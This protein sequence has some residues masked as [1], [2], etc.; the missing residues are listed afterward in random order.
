MG[1]F[2]PLLPVGGQPAV[3]RCVNIAEKAGIDD[4]LLVTGFRNTEVED[5]V[6][7]K[8]SK[9]RLTHNSSYM[10]G[11]FTSVC[12]GVSALKKENELFFLLP[13]DCCAIEPGI[14]ALLIESYDKNDGKCVIIPTH[15]GKR[16]HPP[17]IP[18][19]YIKRI[20]SYCGE[21]GMQGLLAQLPVIEVETGS[22]GTL[23]DMDTP[24][25]YEKL[26]EF[27]CYNSRLT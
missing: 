4:I 26:L 23:M 22:Q 5:V 25:D 9:V 14:F 10:K 3:M 11:M 17:L 13:V 2:K 19:I 21:N 12:A 20:L 7:T 15:D 16:G 18:S 8:G 6:K 27:V 24:E 1:S